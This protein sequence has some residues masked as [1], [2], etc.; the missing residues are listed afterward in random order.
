MNAVRLAMGQIALEHGKPKPKPSASAKAQ[1]KPKP[2]GNP[3]STCASPKC[4]GTI[5]LDRDDRR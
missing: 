1:A 2:N 5:H 3:K 4:Q